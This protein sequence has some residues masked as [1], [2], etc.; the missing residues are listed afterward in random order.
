MASTDPTLF[1]R[2]KTTVK[3]ALK[4]AQQT[5][6]K[7]NPAINPPL[8]APIQRSPIHNLYIVQIFFCI[9]IV[10]VIICWINGGNGMIVGLSV[11]TCAM[12]G[13]LLTEIR[14]INGFFQLLTEVGPLIF[15]IGLLIWYI[16]IHATY[17]KYI[18]NKQMPEIWYTF[19]G[20]IGTIIIIQLIQLYRFVYS[21]QHE[22]K[23]P[24]T[25]IETLLMFIVSILFAWLVMIEYIIATY[26]RT[27]G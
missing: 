13:L 10:G 18:I 11:I 22:S 5:L 19:S 27:D 6:A 25:P 16:T 9:S 8:N 2:I 14:E 26:Y 3:T 24:T 15:I 21:L 20:L 23:N 4:T 1:D 12:I 17:S 7:E